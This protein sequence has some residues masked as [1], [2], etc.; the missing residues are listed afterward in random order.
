VYLVG[1][2]FVWNNVCG[3]RAGLYVASGVEIDYA[4]YDAKPREP[5]VLERTT[6][7]HRLAAP[8][9]VYTRS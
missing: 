4:Y 8:V 9:P 1:G 2:N 3:D 6:G 7:T 5:V